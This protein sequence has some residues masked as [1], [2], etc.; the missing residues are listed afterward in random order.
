MLATPPCQQV[1]F[2]AFNID[3]GPKVWIAVVV[4]PIVLVSWIKNL[5]HLGPISLLANLSLFVG[6]VIVVYDMIFNLATKVK[7]STEFLGPKN[8][9]ETDIP[10]MNV[11]MYLGTTFYAFEGIGC[12]SETRLTLFPYITL[13]PLTQILPI[14]NKMKQ[15]S[16]APRIIIVGM[17]IVVSVFVGFSFLGF[18]AFG[19]DLQPSITYNLCSQNGDAQ[20]M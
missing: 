3:L 2:E 20:T 13:A 7:L 4:I 1:A 6:L 10:V 5:K 17:C 12:V 8:C 18:L 9:D 15:P 11:A 19:Y 16:H 14:E